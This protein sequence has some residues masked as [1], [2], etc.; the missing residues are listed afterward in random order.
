MSS[1]KNSI[2]KKIKQL[3]WNKYIGEENGISVCQCCQFTKITQMD[4]H[5]GHI[6]SNYNG[7][8]NILTNLIPICSLCNSSM[9]TC[10][11]NDFIIKHGLQ[12]NKKIFDNIDIN[13]TNS[14]KEKKLNISVDNSV[15]NK[16]NIKKISETKIK[17]NNKQYFQRWDNPEFKE[18]VNKYIESGKNITITNYFKKNVMYL[19]I[20]KCKDPTNLN[21]VICKIGYTTNLYERIKSLK[22]NYNCEIYIINLRTVDSQTKEKQFHKMIHIYRSDLWMDIMIIGAKLK[23]EFYVFDEWIVENFSQIKEFDKDIINNI[24]ERESKRQLLIL[25]ETEE[26]Q[27]NTNNVNLEEFLNLLSLAKLRQLCYNINISSCGI[28]DKV[29]KKIINSNYKYNDINE[30][31]NKNNNYKYLI[32]CTRENEN[33]ITHYYYTNTDFSNIN[34]IDWRTD[35][36]FI[37][38]DSGKI[39]EVC[40]YNSEMWIYINLFYEEKNKNIDLE[41]FLN[42]MTFE[43]LKQLCYNFSIS[44]YEDR[45]IIKKNIKSK[46]NYNDI[47]ESINRFKKYKYFIKCYGNQYKTCE[48]YYISHNNNLISHCQKCYISH[49]YYTNTNFS[50]FAYI[51]CGNF[52]DCYGFIGKESGKICEVCNYN[53]DMYIYINPFYE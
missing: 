21:R 6:I 9:G 30:L 4:F 28:K 23:D 14:E 42:S 35:H 49:N 13:K 45:K 47:N 31:I 19:I 24:L 1:I 53:T 27:N 38:K 18:L 33:F 32:R 5:C 25:K 12:I 39:C 17:K 50:D 37:S 52:L 10:N 7:G 43:K 46:Y 11:M 20:L 3:V 44:H 8:E 2:P 22:A 26:K 51:K 48:D 16:V 40:N 41:E 15:D 29:I 36:E 34:N